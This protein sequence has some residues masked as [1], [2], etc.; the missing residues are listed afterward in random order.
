MLQRQNLKEKNRCLYGLEK[1]RIY[2]ALMKTWQDYYNLS[3][4]QVPDKKRIRHYK[5]V[6]HNLQ[7]KLRI[8]P[9]PFIVYEAFGLWFYKH[10][11]ELFKEDVTDTLVEKGMIKTI[12]ILESRIR[13][14]KGP[15]M[16]QELIRRDNAMYRYLAEI[17][18]RTKGK[19]NPSN[20]N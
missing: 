16:V 19:H 12:G 5:R 18:S 11:S 13:L 14:D 2:H 20:G 3:K 8:A 1:L 10:N 17:S 6:I 7:D 9:T 15:N 4:E